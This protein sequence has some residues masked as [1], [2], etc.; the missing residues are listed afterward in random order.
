MS[1]PEKS[2]IK[3]HGTLKL[4]EDGTLEGDVSIEYTGHFAVER[5][6]DIDEESETERETDLKDELKAR[7]SS[8]EITNVKIEN[9]T[10]P[11]KPLIDSFHVRVPGYAQRTGKRLFLQ[12][13]F[14]QYGVGPL[15]T[16]TGRKYPI[17]FHFPWSEDD[18]IDIELPAGYALDSPDAPS[19]FGSGKI[20]EYK[21]SLSVTSDG[22]KLVYKR[23]FYF[24]GGG[25]V[26]YPVESYPQLKIYFEA[27][28]KQDN[29]TIALKQTPA[30]N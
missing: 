4:S 27:L 2:M 3:R 30:S 29:H 18:R 5:K 11:V 13:A 21:P 23:A 26:L 7:L 15:F 12:P 6:E 16:T 8:A 20:S 19:P 14:F 17:Y 22:K 24:G 1:P 9:V 10:D 28:H 25:S